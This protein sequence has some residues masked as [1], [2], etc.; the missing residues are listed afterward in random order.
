MG[1]APGR[2]PPRRGLWARVRP[3]H[4]QGPLVRERLPPRQGL[5]GRE[6]LLLRQGLLGRERLLLRWD[7]L[8]RVRLL[9]RRGLWGR[10][11]LPHRQGPLVRAA[12]QG[13]EPGTPSG[14]AGS[15]F[16]NHHTCDSNPSTNRPPLFSFP[17][18]MSHPAHRLFPVSPFRHT[19]H[20]PCRTAN[21]TLLSMAK[22]QAN[23]FC[24]Q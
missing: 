19:P 9:L 24:E 12:P 10:E 14:M 8:G 2:L 7:L 17:Y 5:W 15:S 6:R 22:T 3:L 18:L 13:Q 23:K 4:R 20:A 1:S 21:V 11:R 16:H